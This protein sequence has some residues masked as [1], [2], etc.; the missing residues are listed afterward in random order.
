MQMY[1]SIFLK[2]NYFLNAAFVAWDSEW[3]RVK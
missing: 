2:K 1:L 3:K